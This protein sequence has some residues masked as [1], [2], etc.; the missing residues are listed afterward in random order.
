M[1]CI[2]LVCHLLLGKNSRNIADAS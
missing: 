2:I 1:Y